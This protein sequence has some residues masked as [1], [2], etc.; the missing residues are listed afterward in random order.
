LAAGSRTG[1]HPGLAKRPPPRREG[2]QGDGRGAPR[3]QEG[4]AAQAVGRAA[5]FARRR[6]ADP[7]R[8][9]A[10]AGPGRC[11]RLPPTS[12]LPSGSSAPGR[13]RR[14]SPPAT[15]RLVKMMAR[16]LQARR[17][18]EDTSGRPASPGEP[19]GR[20]SR[21]PPRSRRGLPRGGLPSHVARPGPRLRRRP[22]RRGAAVT[23]RSLPPPHAPP[24]GTAFRAGR[25]A[26]VGSG[27]LDSPPPGL[28][29]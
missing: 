14:R 13:P 20:R 17:A 19:L 15:P 5:P 8:A 24:R 1:T 27:R 9:E 7:R 4:A 22:R 6:R 16:P 25:R 28:G 12:S 21:L 10:R 11:R 23:R 26:S 29:I 3:A 2:G 18:G